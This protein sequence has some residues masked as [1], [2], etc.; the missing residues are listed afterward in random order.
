MEEGFILHN[1]TTTG[2]QTVV[3]EESYVV[4]EVMFFTDKHL[5]Y[6]RSGR[7]LFAKPYLLHLLH[8]PTFAVLLSSVPQMVTRTPPFPPPLLFSGHIAPK[9]TIVWPR[10]TP[11]SPNAPRGPPA[12]PSSRTCTSFHPTQLQKHPPHTPHL[13]RRCG[14]L[15]ANGQFNP[16]YGYHRRVFDQNSEQTS[17]LRPPPSFFSTPSTI[18]TF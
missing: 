3:H 7:R 14:R 1:N 15:R 2:I 16:F 9:T 8:P 13:G 17:K 12:P 5:L 4:T 18:C 11:V 6:S 10:T